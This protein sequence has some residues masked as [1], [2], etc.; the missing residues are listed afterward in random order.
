MDVSFEIGSC[1]D[2]S[3]LWNLKIEKK[4]AFWDEIF[5]THNSFRVHSKPGRIGSVN[6]VC[7][8]I[9]KCPIG[10]FADRFYFVIINAPNVETNRILGN[11]PKRA[12]HFDLGYA[13]LCFLLEKKEQVIES[14]LTSMLTRHNKINLRKPATSKAT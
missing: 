2:F 3:C 1:L 6:N 12:V 5:T 4:L 10:C 11:F 9:I 14:M 8:V 7:R 13:V